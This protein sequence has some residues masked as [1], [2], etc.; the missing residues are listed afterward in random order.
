M[1]NLILSF[2]VVSPLFIIMAL[3]YYL[4]YTKLL[5]M[6]TLN[7]MNKICFKI[8]LPLLLF[9]NIY[10]SDVK[11]AFDINLILFSVGCV[12]I[13][14]LV[15]LFVIPMIEKENKKRGVIIQGIFRSNFVIFGLP[16]ATSIYGEGNIA[17]TALLVAFIVPLF[18]LLAVISL[19]VFREGDI[20]FKKIIKGIVSNPLII[21]AVIAVTLVLFDIKLPV[22]IAKSI[23]DIS[24][25]GT[26][27]SLMLLGGSFSFSHVSS[28]MKDTILVVSNKLVFVPLVF[29]PISVMLGF[30]GIELLTLLLIFASPTAVS[31]FQ[32][33]K[34]MDGDSVL[35]EQSIVF[36]CLFCI[37]TVFVWILVLKQFA[38]I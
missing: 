29:V 33:A 4:K 7:V 17:T 27:L 26:P 35:A 1:E 36:S 22:F 32:M 34:E 24:K 30:R 11:S 28:Y 37:P 3:G 5:D 38:L 16:V 18:N 6:N 12:I 19:E 8:F 31:S 20:D 13:L 10:T 25:I 14:F 23:S 21:A 15:L 2:N 9:N